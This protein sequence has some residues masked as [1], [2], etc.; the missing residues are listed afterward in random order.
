MTTYR[1]LYLE[2]AC[3]TAMRRA[4]KDGVPRW[5]II[6]YDRTWAEYVVVD[7]RP[8]EYL[9]STEEEEAK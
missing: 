5:V 3:V 8:A 6:E 1:T 2:D 4:E 7:E 9:F